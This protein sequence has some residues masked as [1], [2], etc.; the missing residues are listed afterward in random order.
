[1]SQFTVIDR[2]GTTH[3]ATGD[4]GSTVM[5]L[6]R[7]AGFQEDFA[8]CGGYCSCATCHVYIEDGG[9]ERVPAMSTEE[10]ALLDGS[11]SR[12]SNSRLSCQVRAEQGLEG[13]RIVIAPQD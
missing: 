7:D 1:M 4:D 12:R 11:E 10:D 3:A 8:L 5:E 13:V 6:I 9:F 2:V